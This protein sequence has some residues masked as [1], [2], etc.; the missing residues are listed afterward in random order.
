MTEEKFKQ[1]EILKQIID[2]L[3]RN[4]S[5]IDN[6]IN[7]KNIYC[8]ISNDKNNKSYITYDFCDKEQIINMLNSDKINFKAKLSEVQKQFD[9]L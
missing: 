2:K 7:S 8:N 6:L 5:I 4:I 9:N 3:N 1:L